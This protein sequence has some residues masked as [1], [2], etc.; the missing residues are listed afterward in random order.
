MAVTMPAVLFLV[1]CKTVLVGDVSDLDKSNSQFT[2]AESR[3][4]KYEHSKMVCR[5]KKFEL[6]D[7]AL[8]EATGGHQVLA[9]PYNINAC[10]RAGIVEGARWNATHQGSAYRWWR[11]ACPTPIKNFGPDG[12]KNT[13]DDETIGWADPPC[14]HPETVTCEPLP[15]EI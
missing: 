15:S 1:L 4:W 6:A 7:S 5:V 13:P 12:E 11:T 9:V 10:Q 8:V 3:A 14:G 2:G